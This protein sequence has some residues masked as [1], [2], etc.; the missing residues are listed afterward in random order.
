VSLLDR[1]SW[2]AAMAVERDDAAVWERL[3]T[4]AE[5]IGWPC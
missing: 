5:G 4:I 3:L 1:W 2:L